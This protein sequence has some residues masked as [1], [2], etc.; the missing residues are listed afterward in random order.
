MGDYLF[1]YVVIIVF[2]YQFNIIVW[3]Q[4][5]VDFFGDFYYFVFVCFEVF[6]VKIVDDVMYFGLIDVVFYVGE[7]IK[8]FIVFS[9]FWCFIGWYFG[10]NVCGQ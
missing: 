1:M 6:M 7:V 8:I 4:F 9:G 10:M 5:F 2:D 3:V